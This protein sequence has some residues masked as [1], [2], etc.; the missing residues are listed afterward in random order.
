[1][2]GI[3]AKISRPRT[4]DYAIQGFLYQFNK[5]I[6]A[7]L[8]SADGAEVNV[9][10]LIE[11]IDIVEPLVTTAIQCK[12]HEGQGTFSL[13]L[14]YKPVLEMLSHFQRNPSA[15]VKYQLFCYFPNETEPA[16]PLTANDVETIL[17]TKN[18]ALTS[19]AAALKGKVDIGVFLD[20]FTLEFGPSLAEMESQICLCFEQCGF[21]KEDIAALIYPNALHQ[22]AQM[23][24]KHDIA[25]RK[26][27]KSELISLLNALK[28]TTISRWTL[29]LKTIKKVL[30]GRKKQLRANLSKNVRRR[31]FIVSETAAEDFDQGIVIFIAEFLDKYHFKAAH[32][33]PPLFCLDCN[34]V[35]FDEIRDR[36]HQ[37]GIRFTDGFIGSRFD[38]VH[39]ARAPIVVS[40]SRDRSRTE[41][42][43]R[44]LRYQA[45]IELPPTDDL[46]VISKA[47]YAGI[48]TKDLNEERLETS[49]LLQAKFLLG[50]ANTYE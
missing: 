12:Y 6:H 1:M 45:G 9:E 22:V 35:Q 19:L 43:I 31:S 10:G 36:I 42:S 4:A 38:P 14:I 18:K 44:L 15:N 23:S 50:V 49:T 16:T 17:E 33:E 3:A 32:L 7:V 41:F 29:A 8:Q 20:R 21:G 5:T 27:T 28:K 13:G 30:E 24:I 46:F 26:I 37:K 25:H 2:T 47:Q 40:S 11:D 48:P 34:D 39:F